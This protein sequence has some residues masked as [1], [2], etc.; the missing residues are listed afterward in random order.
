MNVARRKPNVA[1]RPRP[2]HPWD[3]P[4]SPPGSADDGV[5]GDDDSRVPAVA[6]TV[7]DAAFSDDARKDSLTEEA[8]SVSDAD[9]V[10]DSV[11]GV[12]TKTATGSARKRLRAAS[13]AYTKADVPRM[14][15]ASASAHVQQSR[16]S[17]DLSNTINIHS[18]FC[19]LDND[20]S[21]HLFPRLSP[22]AQSVYLRLYRQSFGWNRNWAAESLPKLSK[23]C[24][25]SLQ[26]IRKAIKE[27][28]ILGC[29]RK[30]FSDYHKATVYRV[31]LPS[32][33]GM[34][35]SRLSQ[36][37]GLNSDIPSSEVSDG[38][39]QYQLPPLGGP[40]DSV[41]VTNDGRGVR[42]LE[43]G[44]A[45]L[46]VKNLSSSLYISRAQA[47]TCFL[48]AAARFLKTYRNT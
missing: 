33:L 24:N 35:K 20:V 46:G 30:E 12:S 43:G 11:A 7:S 5:S 3:V 42:N 2:V 28:E 44:G 16:K 40:Q 31:L 8:G 48:K 45:D 21:D 38:A 4:V 17:S 29:I 1:K 25:L 19:K 39:V 18:N 22:S 15:A 26:T 10:A 34:T 36:D 13:P 23:C 27:L 47:F 37:T 14:Q 32:E 41:T 9:A 6:E